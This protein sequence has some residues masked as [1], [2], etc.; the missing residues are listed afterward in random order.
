MSSLHTKAKFRRRTSHEPNR[1]QMSKILCSPSFAFDL[2]HVKYSV[3]TGP[4]SAIDLTKT[5]FQLHDI[6]S[7][8]GAK[9]TLI[10]QAPSGYWNIFMVTRWKMWS[11]NY[12]CQKFFPSR[13]NTKTESIQGDFLHEN[14]P[15]PERSQE[16]DSACKGIKMSCGCL[17]NKDP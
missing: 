16:S 5:P 10:T 11:P 14:I 2:A 7:Y 3:W 8:A 1:M 13:Q 15:T 9:I 4:K 17:E 6:L 12:K